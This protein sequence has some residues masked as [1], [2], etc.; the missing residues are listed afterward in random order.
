MFGGDQN[1]FLHAAEDKPGNPIWGI[2]QAV[3]IALAV[4]V[5]IYFLFIL[6]AQVDGPSMFPNL[7]DK[8]LLFANK[9][10][11]W[12]GNT[13]WG[14]QYNLDFKK[15][16]IIIF[17]EGNILLVK[18]IIAQQ[19]DMVKIE[20]GSVYVNG[21][22]LNE[23]YLEA[24]VQTQ[25]PSADYATLQEGEE[26]V[27]PANSYFMLGDNRPASKDSRYKDIGYV[28]RDKIKG[29]VFFRFWPSDK[30]GLINGAKYN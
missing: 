8:E 14:K 5:T 19:G 28:T 10:P 9:I 22:K 12:A 29:V 3:V 13:S 17:D 1:P 11:T 23:T 18:R 25:Y 6:P 7:V 30:L 2:V 15:G 27:V 21:E 4:N 20:D 24:T 16:D 26:G